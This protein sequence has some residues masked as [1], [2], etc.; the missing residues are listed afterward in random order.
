MI[1]K[2]STPDECPG[3]FVFVNVRWGVILDT[4][5]EI[6]EN[7]GENCGRNGNNIKKRNCQFGR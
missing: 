4:V 6:V 7:C 3:Y 5:G 1:G 2:D